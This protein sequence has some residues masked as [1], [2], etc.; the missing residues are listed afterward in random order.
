[1]DDSHSL[2]IDC[3]RK[4]FVAI[5]VFSYNILFAFKI[6]C[7]P[8]SPFIAT[9]SLYFAAEV[10]YRP[11]CAKMQQACKNECRTRTHTLKEKITVAFFLWYKP[12]K[13]VSTNAFTFFFLYNLGFRTQYNNRRLIFLSHSGSTLHYLLLLLTI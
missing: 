7:G 8:R 1:M 10:I 6:P 11:S 9:L 3:T 13:L 5:S 12:L 2:T 4:R